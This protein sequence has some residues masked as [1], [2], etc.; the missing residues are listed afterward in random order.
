MGEF[1]QVLKVPHWIE[2]FIILW[3]LRKLLGTSPIIYRIKK[4][5]IKI[6]IAIVW[7]G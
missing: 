6:Y 5:L 3:D 7:V 2:I 4:T 1:K